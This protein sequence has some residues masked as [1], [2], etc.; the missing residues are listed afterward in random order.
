MSAS[1][2]HLS[3]SVEGKFIAFLLIYLCWT[4]GLGCSESSIR[5]LK[6]LPCTRIHNRSLC[7]LLDRV[8]TVPPVCHLHAVLSS[9]LACPQNPGYCDA[10]T[11]KQVK[12]CPQIL[13]AG[14][15]AP[16]RCR[17]HRGAWLPTLAAA[18]VGSHLVNMSRFLVLPPMMETCP[19]R[20]PLH[21]CSAETPLSFE[22]IPRPFV[23]CIL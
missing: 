18:W 19:I 12:G 21:G 14:P 6:P 13:Q 15:Q 17:P 20:P 16:I 23:F 4:S 10:C 9:R 11:R 2:L 3:Y 5:E 7:L 22:F 1:D 8:H